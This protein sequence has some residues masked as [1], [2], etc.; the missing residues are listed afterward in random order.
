MATLAL[1]ETSASI[2]V[3][4]RDRLSFAGRSDLDTSMFRFIPLSTHSDV[5]ELRRLAPWPP[6]RSLM[7]P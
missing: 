2:D 5:T 3:V 7:R 1:F 6:V 4:W